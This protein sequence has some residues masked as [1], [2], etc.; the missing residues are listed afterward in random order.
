MDIVNQARGY[1]Y[2]CGVLKNQ[3]ADPSCGSC[4]SFVSALTALKE[5]LAKL[6]AQQVGEA[7]H[8]PADFSRLLAA[9][10]GGAAAIALPEQPQGQKK[11][12]NCRLP[13]GVCFTKSSL[14]ILQK[15]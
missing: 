3:Q 7:M 6:E 14:A 1:A 2:L 15:L 9:A 4:N 10:R 11:A 8:L 13:E 12:G 5:G